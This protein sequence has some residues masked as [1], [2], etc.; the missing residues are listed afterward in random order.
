MFDV[1]LYQRA[2]H[3]KELQKEL[4]ETEA[5]ESLDKRISY[6]RKAHYKFTNN[7]ILVN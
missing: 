3:M 1:Y 7:T 6:V 4:L 2:K 5:E